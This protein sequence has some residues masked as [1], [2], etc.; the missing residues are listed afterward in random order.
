M[1]RQLKTALSLLAV[2]GFRRFWVYGLALPE[3]S[4]E[5]LA[6]GLYERPSAMRPALAQLPLIASPVWVSAGASTVQAA[7]EE[8]SF[9][10]SAI[11]AYNG[12][13]AKNRASEEFPLVAI[14]IGED[15]FPPPVRLAGNAAA[16]NHSDDLERSFVAIAIGEDGFATDDRTVL[17]LSLVA[18][19]VL[20]N[21]NPLTVWPSPAELSLVAVAI[22]VYID[23]YPIGQTVNHVSHI[24]V[25]P[26]VIAFC[27]T[28][29]GVSFAA[30]G[31]STSVLRH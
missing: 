12:S 10:A 5:A 29:A 26:L 31:F 3:L 6:I 25:T 19:I 13:S 4:L 9:A 27:F 18:G 1:R 2:S 20:K 30:G 7:I 16:V 15:K 11:C 24:V 8:L 22:G 23:A 14:A 21:E 28:V 17:E